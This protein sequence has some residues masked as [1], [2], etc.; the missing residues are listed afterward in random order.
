MRS[1][2]FRRYWYFSH[3][4]GA[5]GSVPHSQELCTCPY[6]E[7]N[8]PIPCPPSSLRFILILSFHL[9]LDLL[10]SGLPSNTQYCVVSYMTDDRDKILIRTED[11]CKWMLEC[12]MRRHELEWE[13]FISTWMF[14][15]PFN[16]L[17]IINTEIT[18]QHLNCIEI[19]ITNLLTY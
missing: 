2:R 9:L 17:L 13:L 5:E 15:C 1:Y 14:Q 7:P 8:Q 16:P 6:P 11:N 18:Y 19:W 4:M 12:K 3:F 10:T